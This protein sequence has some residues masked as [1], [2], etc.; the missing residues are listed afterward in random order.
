MG[1]SPDLTEV[2]VDDLL[3]EVQRR[4]LC[5]LK[6]HKRLILIGTLF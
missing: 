3:G 5:A 2:P 1:G 4:M 6:P